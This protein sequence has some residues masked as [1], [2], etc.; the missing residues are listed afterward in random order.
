MSKKIIYLV[1]GSGY[2]FR[3]YHALPPLYRKSDN[4]PTGAVLGFVNMLQKLIKD[5]FINGEGSHLAL[6]FDK[7]SKT[8]RNKIFSEYKANRGETPEDL[9]PQ[10]DLIKKAT[11]HFNVEMVEMEGFEA[12]DIIASYSKQASEENY[13]VI[14]VSSD[15]DL[16]QLV[17]KNISMLDPMK[18]KIIK[19]KEVIEKFGV[20]PKKVIDVQSLAGDSVDN[21]PGVPG[22][23]VKIAAQLI[24]EYKNLDNLLNNASQIK[25]TKRR[26]RLVEFA[27]DARLS[28]ELVTL[29]KDIDLK[30]SLFK[31]KF[32]EP[33]DEDIL[34]LYNELEFN[35]LSNRLKD[36]ISSET[37]RSIDNINRSKNKHNYSLLKNLNQL[38]VIIEEIEKKGFFALNLISNKNDNKDLDIKGLSISLN[39]NTGYFLPLKLSNFD[40]SEIDNNDRMLSQE[41]LIYKKSM[42][43]IKPLLEDKGILKIVYNYK[44]VEKYFFRHGVQVKSFTDVMVMSYNISIGFHSH[45]LETMILR[46]LDKK[47][48][49][50]SEI[51]DKYKNKKI[52]QFIDLSLD[53]ATN[54]AAGMVD[55]IL[56]IW[57]HLKPKM[58]EFSLNGI[59]E[60]IDKPLLNVL[61]TMEGTGVLVDSNVLERISKEFKVRIINLEKKIYFL[62]GEKFNIGS[63]KQL[64]EVLFNKLSLEG[65]KKSKAGSWSTSADILENLSDSGHEVASK[66]LEWRQISKLK[67]TY[68]DKLPNVINKKTHRVH[69]TY[70]IANTST[71]RLSSVEPNLQ[72]I[73]IRTEDGRRIRSAF[74]SKP[75]FS[76]I[77]A[78]Y[79]QIELRL[80]AHMAHIPQLN[81]AF[82]NGVDI[83]SM[84]A[85]EVFD[86]SISDMSTEVRRKAKAINFGIIYGISSY[87]LAKQLSISNSEAKEYINSYFK[88]FPGILEYMENQKSFC[89]D[90][91]FVKTLFNRRINVPE[92]NNKNGLRRSFAERQAINAPLQGGAADIIKR[93]MIILSNK[94]NLHKDT[95]Y[96]LLQVHDELVFEVED[97]KIK[98]AKEIIKD[99]MENVI[100]LKVPLTIDLG[101]GKNWDEAH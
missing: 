17:N 10:F 47:F 31:F 69:T 8:F 32:K 38:E 92:I 84:T 70:E 18:S 59:Y 6:I 60:K 51:I 82:K 44:L 99:T 11:K 3:A 65:G 14:I 28:R 67:N 52:N 100:E 77:S 27:S 34:K 2:I 83:H 42:E 81:N 91:G 5:H 76:L 80:L 20:P 71:G 72:N 4:T 1:D 9:I 98:H 75:N 19:E 89:R 85:S 79:S 12:D 43:L 86:V 22:I 29:K 57:L 30:K 58:T 54:Y 66:V 64:G 93:A 97:S 7:G 21:I 73:P 15:K 101:I 61:N 26:E 95:I 16:M 90:N 96:M 74:I 63:P 39:K 49:L 13:D 24:I 37:G 56:N 68:S 50:W 48:L 40:T 33:K 45:D 46:Y 25:Q 94:I 78:D 62:A 36:K 88:K 41:N 35:T 53:D 87:G 55:A 23:G